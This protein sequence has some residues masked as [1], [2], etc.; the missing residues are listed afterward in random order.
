MDFLQNTVEHLRGLPQKETMNFRAPAMVFGIGPG[1]L[2]CYFHII[3]SFALRAFG[4]P[5]LEVAK[6]S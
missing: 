5:G 6:M 2:C 1:L 3:P 4:T